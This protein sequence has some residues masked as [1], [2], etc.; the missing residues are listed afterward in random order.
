M[1]RKLWKRRA[2]R[3]VVGALLGATALGQAVFWWSVWLPK[4]DVT[5]PELG[6][7][8][9]D[10]ATARL[11][12]SSLEK[13]DGYWF[14]V[15]RGDAVTMGAE[16][17]R[18]GEFLV[19]RV[20][21]HMMA[22]FAQRM[23][24]LV[25]A[26]LPGVLMWQYRR[27]PHAIPEAQREELWGF[28]ETHRDHQP[29]SSY[30][31]G[32]FYHALHDITQSLVGNPWV[33]PSV[34]GAC[35]GFGA[36]GSWTEDGHLLLGRNFDF[37]T[38]PIFD[39][40]KVV[41][42]FARE[43]VLPVLSV[44]WMGL[45][46]VISGMNAD[47]IWISLNAARSEGRSKAGP[48]VS[49]LVRDVLE[50]ARSLD[51]VQR[52]LEVA[53][54][55][56]SDIY[57]VGDGKTGEMAIFERGQTRMGRRGPAGDRIVASN[58]LLSDAFTG[59]T[60]DQG[61]RDYSSTLAR[62]LRMRE[63]IDEGPISVPRAQAILRDRQGP[64]GVELGLG[65]RN[66][67]DALIATHSVIADATDRVLWVSTAP[68]TQGEY[69]AIDLLGELEAA[70]ID[71]AAWRS[72]LPAGARAWEGAAPS[73]GAEAAVPGRIPEA[74]APSGVPEVEVSGSEVLPA[75]KP[76]PFPPSDLPAG[77]LLTSGQW[78]AITSW[79]ALIHDAE[80]ALAAGEPALG[81][82]LARRADALRPGSDKVAWL[83]ADACRQAGDEPCARAAFTDYLGRYPSFGPDHVRAVEWLEAHGGVPAIARPD[84]EAAGRP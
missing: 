76:A 45:S 57:L 12:G 60:D 52:L 29:L 47:G 54:P 46:G 10:G 58:H 75:A 67:I 16:H 56:V 40:E 26:M 3:I 25:R 73:D 39:A 44:S 79:V 22:D 61:L 53:T 21:A 55:M 38:F 24:L 64:G 2:F 23:P 43:G 33:D 17:A 74:E 78:P 15:H 41:H 9:I 82:D 72:G 1:F 48:P 34:A 51:D 20:E 18:L 70:G 69:R 63:L 66:A 62:H 71:T 83:V 42:L 81:E 4:P 50:R 8:V 30:R 28:G 37:E 80:A 77:D 7:P 5:V 19:N 11:G 6:D 59:D 35:T 14:F 36:T 27:M 65:N 49:L 13:R 32:L 31:R 68:H 84:V